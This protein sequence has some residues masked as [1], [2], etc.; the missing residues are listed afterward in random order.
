MRALA[1]TAVLSLPLAAV[2]SF[3]QTAQGQAPPAQAPSAEKQVAP[4]PAPAPALQPA[5]PFP[6]GA[7]VAYVNLQRIAGESVEGRGSNAK[8]QAYTQKKST[9]LGEK[10]RL[11]AANQQKLQQTGPMLSDPARA[12]LEKD[13]EKLQVDIQRSQ[14][15]AQAE[16]QD[17]QQELQQEFQKKL[18]PIIQQVVTERNLLMLFSQGDAGIIWADGGLDLTAEVVKRFDAATV[19]PAATPAPAVPAPPAAKPPAKP[20]VD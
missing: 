10:Q 6:E 12:Q 20:P 19:A 9:E 4:P 5:R 11:L 15:D 14:Q 16:I 3:A 7:R 1:I 18:L 2:P 17:L 13:I 8:V